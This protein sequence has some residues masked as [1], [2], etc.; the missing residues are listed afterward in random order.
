MADGNPLHY[1]SQI[2]A[3][4]SFMN[5]PRCSCRNHS[6]VRCEVGRCEKK[7]LSFG[8]AHF[9]LA[10]RCF[11]T[12]V[13]RKMS[14]P[15]MR[16]PLHLLYIFNWLFHVYFIYTVAFSMLCVCFLAIQFCLENKGF[17]LYICKGKSIFTCI[18]NNFKKKA[19][20]FISRVFGE[21]SRIYI[22]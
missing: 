5:F 21:C 3:L 6:W 22:R 15:L 16:E 1:L 12:R 20:I 2:P 18:L 14:S 10:T 7:V 4:F 17:H 8:R 19:L 11:A 13:Q 9:Q